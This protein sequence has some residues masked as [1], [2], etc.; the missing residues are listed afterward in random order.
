MPDVYCCFLQ[1]PRLLI[2]VAVEG[3]EQHLQPPLVTSFTMFKTLAVMALACSAGVDARELLATKTIA[4]A[5]G[6]PHLFRALERV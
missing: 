3:R 4:A 6:T 2:S 1:R 5:T